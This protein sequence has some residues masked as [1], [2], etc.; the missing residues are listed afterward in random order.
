[1]IC[2]CIGMKFLSP[3]SNCCLCY[4]HIKAVL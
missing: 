1:V 4:D 3:V 2:Q